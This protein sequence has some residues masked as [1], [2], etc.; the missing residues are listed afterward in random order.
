M[1]TNSAKSMIIHT[2]SILQYAIHQSFQSLSFYTR[3]LFKNAYSADFIRIN[4][5]V[6]KMTVFLSTLTHNTYKHGIL[7]HFAEKL[8]ALFP[9]GIN[10]RIKSPSPANVPARDQSMDLDKM[11][12]LG[13]NCDKML[14][15]ATNCDRSVRIATDY[16]SGP[17]CT[18]CP[19]VDYYNGLNLR[20]TR[21]HYSPN[22]RI[23][24]G[25]SEA[26]SSSQ[27][28][29]LGTLTPKSVRISPLKELYRKQQ[30]GHFTANRDKKMSQLSLLGILG[31]S[32]NR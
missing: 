11:L 12:P 6:H 24:L 21:G 10:P 29:F 14:Q 32:C 7:N 25:K 20:K 9:L 18:I 1:N 13:K 4:G 3:I 2:Y 8:C 5:Q 28:S 30:L 26:N 27:W 16:F 19:V 31:A 22:R 15:I 23:L 17:D